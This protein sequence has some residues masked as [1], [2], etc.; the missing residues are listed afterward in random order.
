MP[1]KT[2]KGTIQWMAGYAGPEFRE[3]VTARETNLEVMGF[4]IFQS[5]GTDEVTREKGGKTREGTKEPQ[6]P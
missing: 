6:I 2:P 5:M 1:W 3:E 4:R